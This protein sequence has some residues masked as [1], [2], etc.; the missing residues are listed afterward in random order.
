MQSQRTARE[1]RNVASFDRMNGQ[2]NG[3]EA[4]ADRHVVDE[5]SLTTASP[6]SPRPT[7]GLT[8]AGVLLIKRSI[9]PDGR[10]D[11]I[12]VQIDLLLS[13]QPASQIK[14]QA[15]R[16]L[17]LQTEI[18]REY[19]SDVAES[20]GEQNGLSIIDPMSPLPL[21][22]EPARLLDIGALEGKWGPRYFINV[23][24]GS[25]MARLFGN[26]K[27]LVKHLVGVGLI[28]TP[29]AISAGLQLDLPCR[30]VIERSADGRFLNVVAIY[31][32][33]ARS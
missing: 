12:P 29:E 18:I 25:Q 1:S 30:A 5:R 8:P 4:A 15:K 32:A 28:L 26:P 7:P 20:D 24:V 16:A 33:S 21:P 14:A 23:K 19:L 11:S 27:Q 2:R 13:G 31:P 22:G 6:D 9:S 17:K 3:R 10:I